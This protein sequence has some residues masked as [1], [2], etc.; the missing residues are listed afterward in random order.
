MSVPAL[1][2]SNSMGYYLGHQLSSTTP[3]SPKLSTTFTSLPAEVRSLIYQ[4]TFPRLRSFHTIDIDPSP[5][6][7]EVFNESGSDRSID[8]VFHFLGFDI[9]RR[10]P[11]Q[12]QDARSLMLVC[13]TTRQEVAPL[14]YRNILFSA[15]S[16]EILVEV[17]GKLTPYVKSMIR[18]AM[19]E[20]P[21]KARHEATLSFCRTLEELTGLEALKFYWCD[22]S[23]NPALNGS[24]WK[25]H[26]LK[27]LKA[28]RQAFP[29][30]KYSY[31][32]ED[33]IGTKHALVEFTSKEGAT[34]LTY[35]PSPGPEPKK[36]M[37][38]D[39]DE[40]LEKLRVANEKRRRSTKH[41][42]WKPRAQ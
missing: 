5:L 15:W 9:I 31:Y 7:Y 38:F 26:I 29:Q 6:Y 18:F 10:V 8:L 36:R 32:S 3:Q 27:A 16:I 22:R 17:M 41:R 35:N 25:S 13:R 1:Q 12:I 14:V 23:A 21:V 33:G 39:L 19:T 42:K 40:E 24:R 20:G 11:Q 28:F 37:V 30:L 34:S 2:P 4:I